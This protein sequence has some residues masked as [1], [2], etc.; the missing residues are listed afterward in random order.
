[1]TRSGVA[2]PLA[3]PAKTA[4]ALC[5]V[6]DTAASSSPAL[7]V[8][9]WSGQAPKLKFTLKVRTGDTKNGDVPPGVPLAP[10]GDT[11]TLDSEKVPRTYSKP[12]G[13]TATVV[14]SG[15]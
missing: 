14:L 5:G 11:A 13:S 8:V 4:I 15:T 2:L 1:M 10:G 7:S 3:P 9:S 6:A 12:A